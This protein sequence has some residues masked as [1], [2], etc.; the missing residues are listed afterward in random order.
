[1]NLN[2][3]Q[4]GQRAVIE[5]SNSGGDNPVSVTCVRCSDNEC[6]RAT[7]FGG[8]ADLDTLSQ[9]WNALNPA[10]GEA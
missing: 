8:V 9:R 4:C 3:C 5:T 7:G 2:S 6:G 10:P 1:M